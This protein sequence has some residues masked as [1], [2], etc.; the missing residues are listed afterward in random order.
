MSNEHKPKEN[1]MRLKEQNRLIELLNKLAEEIRPNVEDT[2]EARDVDDTLA[3]LMELDP[4]T[5]LL[6]LTEYLLGRLAEE[7]LND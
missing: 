5:T 1:V 2:Q 7:D 4:A 3:E 6:A